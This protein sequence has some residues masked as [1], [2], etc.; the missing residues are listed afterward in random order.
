M[1]RIQ[2]Q[3]ARLMRSIHLKPG[4]E[5]KIPAAQFFAG[6][7]KPF[8]FSG[9]VGLT[10][11]YSPDT[12]NAIDAV[13]AL[14]IETEYDFKDCDSESVNNVVTSTLQKVC[15]DSPFFNCDAVIFAR[16]ANLFECKGAVSVIDF[17]KF[18]LDEI[19]YN[20]KSVIGKKC[21]IYPLPRFKGPSL[22]LPEEG[23]HLISCSDDIAWQS[24]SSG[25]YDFDGWT[26]KCQVTVRSRLSF[27][28][29][30]DF[31][32]I[33]LAEEYGT[34][35]GAKFSSTLK[36]R[37]FI[38]VLFAYAS[39]FSKHGYHKSIAQPFTRCMQFPHESAPDQS[40]TLS[41]CGALSPFYASDIII[42]HELTIKIAEWYESLSKCAEVHKQRIK[43]SA[44]F[45]NRA[46]NSDDIESYINYFIA[47]DAL[48]GQ[49]GSVEASII[50]GIGTL[51]L[52]KKSEEK[53]SWLFDLRNEL[54][55]GG[56]RYISEWPKHHRYIKHFGSKPLSDLKYLAQKA[57]LTAPSILILS[58]AN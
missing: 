24:F 38:T 4:Y 53:T 52:D 26:P 44:N 11:W 31:N 33:L 12:F 56:S 49:R 35:K 57:L 58:A 6:R 41:D 27:N 22:C 40:I 2:A 9:G 36:L 32:Y 34:Q 25:G 47:L 19:K 37:M 29:G 30:Y 20:L 50:A 54:V 21:T 8:S 28:G 17:T 1:D 7:G 16:E 3:V 48:F 39:E 15:L 5:D 55:H 23:V 43:K 42:S 46:M 10:W 45:Y 51:G 14:I 13:T 18:I